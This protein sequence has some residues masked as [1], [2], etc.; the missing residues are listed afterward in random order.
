MRF[1]NSQLRTLVGGALARFGLLRS[2]LHRT[3]VIVAFHRVND[4][5]AGDDLTRGTR[6]YESF[7]RF[8]RTHFDV[9]ALSEIVRRL[10]THESIEG[11]LAITHDDGYLDNFQLAAPILDK[12]DLPATFFVSSGFLDTEIIPIWDRE[13]EGELGWMS[14][15]QL[16]QLRDAG[17][18]IGAHTISHVDL[19]VVSPAEARIELV[20]S[21]RKIE[22]ELNRDI[23]LFAYPFGGLNN[24]SDENRAL[25]RETGY[26]C[27]LSCHGGMT[28]DGADLFD[29]PRIPISPWYENTDHLALAMGLRRA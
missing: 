10:E 5:T 11:L 29:L 12:L 28:Q 13:V 15:D 19:G 23:D 7:C 20:D 27:C 26:R 6:D 16:R 14:W 24:L 25:V 1:P 4:Q 9:V 3:G 22:D 2:Q 17:F 21:K 18:D 8:F